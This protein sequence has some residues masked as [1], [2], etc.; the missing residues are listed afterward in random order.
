MGG[1]TSSETTCNNV[2]SGDNF[3]MAEP[4][5][6]VTS[7]SSN[8]SELH[9]QH[10]VDKKPKGV[11]NRLT[12]L[13]VEIF[14]GKASFSRA[15]VQA[16]FEVVSMDHEVEAPL[17]PIVSLDLTTKSGQEILWLVLQSPSLVAIHLG[18]PCGTASKARD[19]P[20]S[21][22]LQ[23]L[24][25]PSPAPLRSA[26]YPLGIPG[27]S[28]VHAT[29]LA[30]ANE[31]Y[32]LGLEII[33][34]A[35]KRQA[36]ISV[37]NPFSSYLWAAL[38]QLTMRH[39]L[40]AIKFTTS[41]RWC[42]FIR[43][44]MVRKKDTGWLSTPG[45]FADLNAVCQGGHDH[46]P[47]GVTYQMGHWKFDTASEAAYPALLS[48][49]AAT[50]L[51]VHA[52]SKGWS[53]ASRPKLHDLA[54]A[55]LNRQS[56]KHKPL[57]PE[58]H[59]VAFQQSNV[60]VPSGAKII[61]PHIGGSDREELDTML[62]ANKQP[63]SGKIKVGYFHTPKQFV[64]LSKKVNHPMDSTEHLEEPTLFSLKFNL[65][66][67]M[68]LV[69]IERKKNILQAKILLK[70]LEGEE[71][72]M[73][74]NLPACLKK[75]LEG[76]KLLL[77]RELLKKYHY[78]DMGVVDFMLKGVP[79]VGVHDAPSCYPELLKPAS[80]TQSDLESTSAWRRKAMLARVP[81]VD[82]SHIDHLI[83]TTDEELSLGFLEGPFFSEDEVTQHL[84]R[85]DWSL[86]RRFVLVQ[87][88]EG[89]LRPIDDCL[90]AQLNF[91]STS[92][93]YLKLQ[94]VDYISG[95]ALKIAAAVS[96]GHQKS[97]EEAWLGKCL[98]LSKAYKRMGILPDHRHLAVIFFHDYT[99]NP[100][101]YV[102][103]SLMFGATA[104]VYSF[105]RVSR[106]L[107][108]LFNRML[109]IPCGVFFDDFPMFSQKELA[110]DADQSASELLDLLGWR[111][112]RTGPK[113]R[114][115]ESC[116]NVLGCSLNLERLEFGE[117]ILENKQGRLERI[118]SQLTSIKD[119]GRMSLHQAQVLHGLLRYSCGF[120][121]GKHL[122]Q[123]CMEIL[124]LG[125]FK[126]LQSRGRLQEFC[127][128]AAECLSSC[129]PRV[130]TSGGDI[131]PV[132]IFT[133]ASWEANVGGIGA[134]VIDTISNRVVIYSGQVVD[135]L[136]DVWLKQVGEHL[137]C[138]LE[139]Y[140]MVC[141]RWSLKS[142]LHNRR[143][144]WW[145]DG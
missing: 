58:Y 98:D 35:F 86:V 15:L 118:F 104:A 74:K 54:T 90:E 92:T 122:Q 142:L 110:L 26:E 11:D 136:R 88:A 103:N 31:L 114:P 116:F 106:S 80:M 127:N 49:R 84:G 95:L 143:A 121:A 25:V 89:K 113:G 10:F 83:E 130:V 96:K 60:A 45:V 132:L 32:K 77:W 94:D 19:R 21:K 64:S 117:V 47:W 41:W 6:G 107:W 134:V 100:R 128:Y 63:L 105:N 138:Q 133:D 119:E 68:H 87:G 145:V 13:C 72:E 2:S 108:Y 123:V 93:S 126:H 97:G 81:V 53:L 91:A 75:V 1:N 59:R 62:D 5:I 14:A 12:P 34:F 144:I 124:Q 115:F 139:L 131:R 36:V 55:S 42:A 70:K 20:I 7:S 46:D 29:K 48:Q 38:I 71:I 76:K 61:A 8:S 33:L 17:R 135:S 120:F 137:I 125:R 16:G 57:I 129:K 27:V 3:T 43:V 4:R 22:E 79:I 67:P 18:L 78:D 30:K 101:F 65:T 37:E 109:L 44:V 102:S 40:E 39:S 73:H 111:H 56:K 50:C 99:G 9:K 66:Y 51:V 69:Q 52:K 85:S 112:A 24:G 140:A 82:P 28:G 23:Q 141:I